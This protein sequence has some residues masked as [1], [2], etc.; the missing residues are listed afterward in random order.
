M[1]PFLGRMLLSGVAAGALSALAASLASARNSGDAT[2][3]M[4]AVAHIYDGG[5][6]PSRPGPGYRNTLIG[7]ALH[8]GASVWWAAFYEKLFGKS[9][10]AAALAGGACVAATAYVV[11]YH[12]VHRRFQPGFEKHLSAAQMLGVYA[13]LALGLALPKL[14][15][16]RHHQ[17]EDAE[18]RGEGR[19][20]ERDP[21]RAVAPEARR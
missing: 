2:R 4:N 10:G 17:P 3:A 21:Q 18:E 11:D 19:P 7:S 14:G 5:K 9:R 12:V 15:R 1:S 8:L 20:A 6:V 13:A 16:L